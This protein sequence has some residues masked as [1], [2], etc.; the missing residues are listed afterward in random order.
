MKKL[1]LIIF[2]FSYPNTKLFCQSNKSTL[3]LSIGPSIPIGNYGKT[4]PYNDL[5]GYAKAGESI[6]IS[7]NYKLIHGIGVEAMLYGQRNGFNSKVFS[8]GLPTEL[9]FS[10][11]GDPRFYSNWTYAWKSWYMESLLLGVTKQ[12][13]IGKP[14]SKVSIFAKALEGIVHVQYP[15]M[16][17]N[18]KSD[19]SYVIIH[20]NNASAFGAS[21]SLSAGVEYKLSKNI[22][23]LFSCEYFGTTKIFFQNID[24]NITATNGGLVVPKVYS[25]SNSVLTPIAQTLGDTGKQTISSANIKLG[26]CF[27]L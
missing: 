21:F 7:F 25:L 13:S 24:E 10:L 23:I 27:T 12:W 2:V 1:V 8:D 14:D 11:G 26:I 5:A 19:T 9:G 4:N 16:S 20:Q 6:N 22:G 18:S 3:S 17:A 15:G